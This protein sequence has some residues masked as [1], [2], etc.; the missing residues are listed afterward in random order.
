MEIEEITKLFDF[1]LENK[2]L[3]EEGI[4][5]NGT[6]EINGGT[7]ES[8]RTSLRINA[9]GIT[10]IRGGTI[11]SPSTCIMN[12]GKSYIS[13]TAN[14]TSVSNYGARNYEGG[15]LEISGGTIQ[16]T[17]SAALSNQAKATTIIKENANIKNSATN[18]VSIAN[19][20]NMEVQ[21]GSLIK[22]YFNGAKK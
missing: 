4:L 18:T 5:N 9:T 13:G 1:I 8:E 14:I 6:M 11:T 10:Y 3:L 16:S 20:G 22:R 12:Y 21:E 7:I 2:S 19:A 17:N 15:T